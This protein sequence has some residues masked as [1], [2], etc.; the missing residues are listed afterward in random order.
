MVLAAPHPDYREMHVFREG[1][2]T[3]RDFN[4]SFYPAGALFKE[5]FAAYEFV[6]VRHGGREHYLTRLTPVKEAIEALGI[7][8]GVVVE[9]YADNR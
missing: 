2:E 8:D 3:I 6:Y 1:A 5:V 4:M 9:I 7:E